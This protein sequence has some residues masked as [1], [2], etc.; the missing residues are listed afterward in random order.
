MQTVIH[1]PCVIDGMR[2]DGM[3]AQY[4][5]TKHNEIIAFKQ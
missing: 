5:K 3:V 4:F 1:V 2:Q